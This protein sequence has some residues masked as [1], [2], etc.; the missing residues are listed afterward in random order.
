MSTRHPWLKRYPI[1]K[2]SEYLIIGTHPP[3]PYCARLN[4]FYG[5]SRVFWKLLD[6]VYCG[7]NLYNNGCP[8]LKTIL[9]F[10]TQNR[11]S[12]TDMIEETDG[13]QFSTDKDMNWTKFNSALKKS[14]IKYP[15]KTIYFTSFSGKNN[16]LS[17]FRKWLKS[18]DVG[19]KDI[20]IPD[21]KKWRGS[22]LTI[23]IQNKTIRLEILLSPSPTARINANKIQEFQDWKQTN[24]T[25]NYDEFR[26]FWYTQ[27]LPKI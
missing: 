11:I 18:N 16:A 15:I 7:N 3:M 27:K 26:V 6:Q 4:Y 23:N 12:I 22:G 25:G 8:N 14:L 21:V 24:P 19:L 5:N 2:N 9:S 20:K 1:S 17:L 10:I 13:G